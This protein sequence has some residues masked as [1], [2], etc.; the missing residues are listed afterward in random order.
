MADEGEGI[1]DLELLSYIKEECEYNQ[2]L[3]V[4][5]A[6]IASALQQLCAAYP[7]V[8]APIEEAGALSE[9]TIEDYLDLVVQNRESIMQD[10][11]ISRGS[12]SL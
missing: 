12:P 2:T 9:L 10:H 6:A 5:M 3:K 11:L 8:K 1:S 4:G 7:R